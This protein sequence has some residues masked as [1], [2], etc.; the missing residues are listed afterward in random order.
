MDLN[1]RLLRA[2][3]IEARIARINQYYVNVLLYKDARCDMR[4]LDE[5][6]GA[7][8]WQRTHEVVNGNLFCNVGIWRPQPDGLGDWIWKQDVGTESNTEAQ[9][10]E[11]SDSFKRACVNWGI[12]REL[13]TA[14]QIKFK[15]ED[16]KVKDGRCYD[17][18]DVAEI[19]YEDRRISWLKVVNDDT[20]KVFTWR[21]GKSNEP[22]PEVDPEKPDEASLNAVK[23]ICKK[24]NI[25]FDDWI[26]NEG[27]TEETLTATNVT[28]MLQAL[29]KKFGEGA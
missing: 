7:E 16:C 3:E 1:F 8:N 14:P 13:Y 12:G 24:H 26:A 2:D 10:G 18:F 28:A 20:Q 17:H 15:T 21:I 11:A 5:T 22:A 27:K 25:S 19:E 23:N 29:N 6:V 9:K 4:I